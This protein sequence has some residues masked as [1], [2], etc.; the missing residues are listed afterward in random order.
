MVAEDGGDEKR[1]GCKRRYSG[2]LDGPEHIVSDTLSHP[3]ISVIRPFVKKA[4]ALRTS[5]LD[6]LARANCLKGM[7]IQPMLWPVSGGRIFLFW[8]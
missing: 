2:T 3:C 7:L 6:K 5:D 8:K 4:L 1:G